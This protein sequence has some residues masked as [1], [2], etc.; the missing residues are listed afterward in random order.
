MYTISD[1]YRLKML[2]QVQT[3]RLRGTIDSISFTES[4]VI[5]VSYSNRCSDKNVSL[6]SV[7]IGTL[8]L[9]FLT[10]ILDRGDYPGKVITISDGLLTGE[11]TYEDIP[12]GTFYIAEAT[13]TAANMISVVAYDCLSKMDEQLNLD[14]S[15]GKIYDFCSYIATETGTT[16]GMSQEECEALP[17]GTELLSPYEFNQ[18]ETWRDMVSALAQMVGGFAYAAKDG[19][20]KLRSFDN[21]PVVNVHKNR[22][23]S[24]AKFSDF[25]TY[26]DTLMYTEQENNIVHY[27][28][29]GEGLTVNIGAN[30]F[31]QYGSRL[32]IERRALNIVDVIKEMRYVPYT[33][34]ILPAFIAL[35]LGDVVSFTDDYTQDTSSGAI[36]EFTWTYNKSFSV[37]CFGNNPNLR[38]GQ[39][40]TDKNISGLIKN[41][42][43]NEVTY[44]NFAN[45]DSITFGS[46][47]EVSIARLRFTSAQKTTVKIL[48]E[49]IFDMLADLSQNGS[50]EVHYYLDNELL[51]Y[52]PYERLGG[53][54]G[55]QSGDTEFSITRD[56]FYILKDVEP[57]IPH[58]WEVRVITHGIEQTTIG[59]NH[60]HVTLEGQRMYGESYFSGVI[61]AKDT[62]SV[63]GY[64]YLQLVSVTDEPVVTINPA[65]MGTASDSIGMYD[66]QTMS[67]IPISEG[68]GVLSPHIYL[69]TEYGHI[70]TESEDYLTTENGDR[71]IL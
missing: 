65:T 25:E 17:N 26:Y 64:G 33:V 62:I 66:F 61:E 37:K 11:D 51:T 15:T 70:L 28:G 5:G 6:G 1:A 29:D 16:F 58:T 23:M 2:D 60:A 63:I 69:Q 48:H 54:Y 30:P 52:S 53:I 49:F 27:V 13:W 4:D 8:K 10:D 67:V 45:V 57:N 55:G 56:L 12:I 71:L 18:M 14:Q 38:K 47:Q 39:S 19:T 34:S 43:E 22:R 32:A 9:T 41:T 59:I 36:M 24:G 68:T 20:W 21:I 42:T 3:H 31:I 7:N 44:Y 50:Y 46:E 40:N 35:D